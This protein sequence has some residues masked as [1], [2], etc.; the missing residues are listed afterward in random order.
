[1]NELAAFFKDHGIDARHE[2]IGKSWLASRFEKKVCEPV[3]LHVA[4]KRYLCA[5][6]PTYFA[7]LSPASVQSLALQGGPMTPAEVTNFEKNEFYR[8]ALALRH[9]DD[10]AKIP[11][12]PTPALPEYRTLLDSIA[13]PLCGG[14]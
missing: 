2:E 13:K 1:M 11:G 12:L 3:Y 10:E 7:K 14:H 8:E 6:D 9:W 4:A 5:T